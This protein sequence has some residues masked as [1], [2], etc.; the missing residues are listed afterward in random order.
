MRDDAP[1]ETKRAEGLTAFRNEMLRKFQSLTTGTA[2][3]DAGVVPG[4]A[5]SW[6]SAGGCFYQ[7]PS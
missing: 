4:C 3:K 5:G 1:E 2:P 6:F 7:R